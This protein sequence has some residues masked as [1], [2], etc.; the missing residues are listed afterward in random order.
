MNRNNAIGVIKKYMGRKSYADFTAG[1]KHIVELFTG[2]KTIEEFVKAGAH[3]LRIIRGEV[4]Q[5][6]NYVIANC[7]A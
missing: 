6:K 3:S 5:T 1:E 4:T 7:I 2:A